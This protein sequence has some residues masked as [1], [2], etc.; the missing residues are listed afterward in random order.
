MSL[1]SGFYVGVSGLNASQNSLNATSHNLANTETKGYVRQQVVQ[2]DSTYMNWGTNHISTL[3]T[4]LGTDIAEVRQIRDIFLDKSYRREE[5]R[6]GFYK[7]QYEAVEEIEGMFGELEGMPFQDSIDDVWTSIQELAKEPDSIVTRASLIQNSVNFIERAENISKQLKDYQVNLNTQIENQVNRI[8]E[9]AEGIDKLNKD[10][11]FYE[12]NQMEQANDLRDS[13]NKLLDE[14][15]GLLNITYSED[16]MG[17]VSVIAE[18]ATLVSDDVVYKLGTAPVSEESDMLKPVWISH[19]NVD[20]FNLEKS[21]S[22]YRDTDIGSLKGLMVARGSNQA[23]YTDIPV[24]TNYNDDASYNEAL[25]NY[26]NNIDSSILMTVEAQFDQLVHGI[27]TTINDIL[28][29]NKEVDI[30]LADGTTKTIK[31]LDEENAPV[32]MD[33]NKTAGEAL[34]NRKSMDRYNEPTYV[35]ILNSDGTTTHTA[36]RVY[37]EENPKDNY[38]LFTIGE[39]E[40]NPEIMNNYSLIPLSSHTGSGDYDI[41]TAEAL[42]TKWQEP[43]ATLSPNTL[44]SN[45]FTSYYT[46]FI[47]E[48]ANRGDQLNTI[49]EN[50]ESMVNSIDEQRQKVLG[51]SSDEELANL[52][53]YQHAYNAS[54]RYITV[55]SQMLDQMISTLSNY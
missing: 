16:S 9:I 12:S 52:I 54:S 10:I 19:G 35:D 29:P 11:R 2:V 41:K 3:Q 44:T 15:G 43:F 34:F 22:T 39:I 17:V 20:L 50:Q 14:L 42:V 18:G 26:N 37:N 28:C 55:I 47:G 40:V 53:K 38:S 21:T 33:A 13:R 27:T 24:R 1:M 8:N 36:V 23:N 48:L 32:G 45:N 25:K 49:S 5:G 4:G 51:V 30:K 7:V 6:Q 46:A 31:I